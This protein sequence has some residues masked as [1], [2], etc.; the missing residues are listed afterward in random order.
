MDGFIIKTPSHFY[1]QKIDESHAVFISDVEE[2]KRDYFKYEDAWL[3]YTSD[4][5]PNI[6]L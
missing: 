6:R 1:D 2:N 4:P 3:L 5:K